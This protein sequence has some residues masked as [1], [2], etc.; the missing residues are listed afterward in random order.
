MRPDRDLR[1]L[2]TRKARH[3][4]VNTRPK[5][6]TDDAVHRQVGVSHGEVREMPQQVGRAKGLGGTLHG[7]RKIEHD[8]HQKEG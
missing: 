3:D 1:W 8:T 6:E 5:E 4:R 2:L 7:A